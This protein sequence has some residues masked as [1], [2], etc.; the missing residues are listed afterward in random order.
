MNFIPL[1]QRDIQFLSLCRTFECIDLD[2]YLKSCNLSKK[3][4]KFRIFQ[5][6]FPL[7]LWKIILNITIYKLILDLLTSTIF[8][9][10]KLCNVLS[11]SFTVH[12]CNSSCIAT[13]FD[14]LCTT[15]NKPRCHFS[16]AVHF[17]CSFHFTSNAGWKFSENV[18]LKLSYQFLLLQ[19]KQNWNITKNRQKS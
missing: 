1:L 16:F 6:F 7:E 19:K 10:S 3:K 13:D 5:F 11:T 9:A 4:P 12:I 15:K 8:E 18:S 2:Q 17:N 14:G